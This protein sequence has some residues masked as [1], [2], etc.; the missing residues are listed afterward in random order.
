MRKTTKKLLSDARVEKDVENAYRDE[1]HHCRPDATVDSPH[2]T[3]GYA[4]WDKVRLLLE[5]KFSEDFKSRM[6]VCN[7]LGQM[8]LYLKKFE[9]AG[10]KLPN[11][12]LVGDKDECFVLSTAS[13]QSFLDMDIDWTVPPSKGN[14]ELTRALVDGLNVLPYVYDIDGRFDFRE[15]LSK[16]ETLA[17]GEQTQVHATEN[18][19]GAIFLHWVNSVFRD[20]D[21]TAVEQVDVFLRC[22]FQPKDVYPHPSR[23]GVL[24]VPGYEDTKS[25]GVLI[26]T[27]LYRSFFDHFQQGYKPSQVDRF[28]AMKDRLMED[29][30]RRRQGA[31][32]TPRLWV[33]EAH[34]ELERV[35]GAKWREDCIVWDPAAG[36]ANLTRD[37]NDWGQLICSTAERPDVQVIKEQGWHRGHEV[38]HYDFLNPGMADQSPFFEP[39]DGDNLIPAS[40]DKALREAAAAG[41]RL[42]FFMNPPYGTANNLVKGTSKAGIAKTFVNGEMK[43]AKMGSPSQQLYAQFMYQCSKVAEQYG[44]RDTTTATFSKP[45]FMSSG[46]FKPFRNWWYGEHA[47]QG[48]FLFQASHFADVS[49]TWGISFTVWNK[50]QLTQKGG[51]SI[52]LCD[53]MG[54]AITTDRVKAICNADGREASKW[55]REP[56]KGIK[57]EDA[58][59]M[60]SGLKVKEGNGCRGRLIPSAFAYMTTVAN[61]PIKSTEGVFWTSSCSSMANGISVLPSNWRRAVALYGARKLVKGDWSSA[62]DEYLAPATTKP[63]YEQ[64]VDDCHLFTMLH[65]QCST[66]AMRDVFYKGKTWRIKN[67]WFWRTLEASQNLYDT[68]G[69]T[70]LYRDTQDEPKGSQQATGDTMALFGDDTPP[71]SSWEEAKA[72]G[73]PYFAHLLEN[74]LRDRLSP[75]ARHVLDLLD[76]LLVKSLPFREDYYT[77]RPVADKKPDLHLLAWDA[78]LYQTKHL[79]RDKLP[80]EWAEL[81]EAFKALAG[82]LQDG[83]YDYGFLKR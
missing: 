50:G 47:Y 9:Q 60:S 2:L 55:V 34:K 22:L 13:V 24:V 77:S 61:C 46:S 38:F 14:P 68:P 25:G 7:V 66:T 37:Y 27:D 63:G 3:D 54:F 80:T 23:K 81:Q 51:L 82:R 39:G 52:R 11:V 65:H 20:P 43:R 64:W 40:V 69:T 36:T 10:D 18:N 74:G 62:T 76:A 1:L 26:N 56:I 30:A 73:D 72:A 53:E 5:A 75:D 48:G 67:H 28:Y 57:G 21:L 8:L 32:F 19:L 15:V 58:P 17:A 70:T 49:G 79:F 12:L 71:T 42:V 83:V 59:Q 31:F 41:K 78:G 16:C 4:R 33:D 35:L 44:F 6:P 29:D 45:T